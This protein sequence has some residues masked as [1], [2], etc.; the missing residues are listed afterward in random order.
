MKRSVRPAIFAAALALLLTAA[1]DAQRNVAVCNGIPGPQ[2]L[3]IDFGSGPNPGPPL[4]RGATS[5]A[6]N[7]TCVISPGEYAI[8]NSMLS[9]RRYWFDVPADHTPN[10]V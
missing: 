7:G 3:H 2:V 9:C 5:Y 10:D 6:Y 1:A 4:P 8:R